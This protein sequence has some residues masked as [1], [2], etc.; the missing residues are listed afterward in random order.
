MFL[1]DIAMWT[2]SRAACSG[3]SLQ[4]IM[5]QDPFNKVKI[6]QQMNLAAKVE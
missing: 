1:Y 5:L 4:Q 2:R 3:T 6:S